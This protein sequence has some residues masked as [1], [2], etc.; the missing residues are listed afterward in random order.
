[1]AFTSTQQELRDI[2]LQ[3]ATKERELANKEHELTQSVAL[4]TWLRAL[5]DERRYL[6]AEHRE[7]TPEL[8]VQ[9][10]ATALKAT[11]GKGVVTVQRWRF[12]PVA[13][14]KP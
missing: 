1:M 2:K 10:K 9:M 5:A 8:K 6:P 11:G 13:P 7:L 14:N 12:C 3:L 4:V